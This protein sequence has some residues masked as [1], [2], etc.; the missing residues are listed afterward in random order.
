M[1]PPASRNVTAETFTSFLLSPKISAL[2]D[3][4]AKIKQAISHPFRLLHI[5][6]LVGDQLV[7]RIMRVHLHS[8][9]DVCSSF[10]APLFRCSILISLIVDIYNGDLELII[11]NRNVPFEGLRDVRHVIMK[12]LALSSNCPLRAGRT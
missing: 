4:H 10:L 5:P 2:T 9:P 12:C 8:P 11:F 6:S 1:C 7:D 3:N